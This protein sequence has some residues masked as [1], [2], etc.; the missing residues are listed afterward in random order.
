MTGRA[1]ADGGRALLDRGG[2]ITGSGAF[3]ILEP[4]FGFARG[5]GAWSATRVSGEAARFWDR[6][7]PPAPALE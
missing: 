1:M 5:R 6:E 7:L 2:A 3:H 4:L